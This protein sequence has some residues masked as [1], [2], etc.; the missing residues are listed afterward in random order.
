MPPLD[1]ILP[2]LESG[3]AS[4]ILLERDEPIRCVTPSGLPQVSTPVL[5]QSQVLAPV[6]ELATPESRPA[7]IAGTGVR[8]VH[9]VNDKQWLIQQDE[10][11][12]LTR[13][14]IH[15]GVDRDATGTPTVGIE[16]TTIRMRATDAPF[17]PFTTQDEARAALEKLLRMRA[18]RGAADLHLRVGEPPM[19]RL[20]GDL[21]RLEDEVTLTNAMV[22]SMRRSVMPDKNRAEFDEQWD[23]DGSHQS[24]ALRSHHHDR[25]SHRVRA[26]EQQVPHHTAAGGGHTQ[27]LKN[28]L[29]AALRE[30]PDIILVGELRDLEALP[31]P[32]Q[33][34][35]VPRHRL[36]H[37]SPPCPQPCLRALTLPRVNPEI[38]GRPKKEMS[39]KLRTLGYNSDAVAGEE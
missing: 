6:S 3:A 8:F 30:D 28:A 1:K 38:P 11:P 26:P 27:S 5:S 36:G 16:S 20:G 35:Q 19:V 21:L 23:T 17:R 14:L 24:P 22:G 7:I 10:D 39:S 18:L 31:V 25:R 13:L 2:R 9:R 12:T 34:Q 15:R 4:R 29:R 32:Q 33:R 37:G